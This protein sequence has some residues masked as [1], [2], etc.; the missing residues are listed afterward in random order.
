MRYNAMFPN[1]KGLYTLSRVGFSKNGKTAV[2]SMTE[3]ANHPDLVSLQLVVLKKEQGLWQKPRA[4]YGA[5][6]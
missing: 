5:I 1:A 6:S 3:I 4:V 2:V